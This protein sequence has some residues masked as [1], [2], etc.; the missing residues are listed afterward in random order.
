MTKK[1]FIRI[2]QFDY[3]VIE[4]EL[5]KKNISAAV[6]KPLEKM[7]HNHKLLAEIINEVMKDYNDLTLAIFKLIEEILP[8]EIISTEDIKKE[9]NEKKDSEN[10]P[11]ENPL[12]NGPVSN[13][14][15]DPNSNP[16]RKPEK[17][18]GRPRSGLN[19]L[20]LGKVTH[21][22]LTP[23]EIICP[24][25]NKNMHKQ[26]TKTRTYV[27]SIPLLST[28]THT[29]E[30]YRCLA[31]N[32]EATAQREDNLENECIGRYHFSAVAALAALRYQCGM[33]SYR[34][35]K[36]S[37]SV[38]IAVSDSTQWSLFEGA[39]SKVQ[40]FV[41]FLEKTLAN[42][43]KKHID[44]THN[45]ILSVVKEIE[46]EQ[47]KAIKNGK[48]PDDVRSG[49]HTTNVTG[50][51][52]YGEIVLYKTGLHHSGEILA[53][54]LSARTVDEQVIIMADASSSN[55][56]KLHLK[57]NEEEN[58]IK[59]ANCNSHALRKF[60]DIAKSEE[61]V[62]KKFHIKNYQ[63][64]ESVSFFL[65]R[66]GQ[67]FKNDQKTKGMTSSERLLFHKNNSFPLMEEMKKRVD[68]A[69]LN[70]E[71]EPNE[72]IGG[73]YKYF[74]NQYPR[75]C[76]FCHFENAPVCNN[77]SE[78]MLKSIIRHRKNSLF[79]KTQ[80]GA[81]VADILTT[82]FFTAK[83]N[84][85]NSVEYLRDLMLYQ[86]HWEKNP[87]EWLPWNYVATAAKL[88]NTTSPA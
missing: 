25:C 59:I 12:D 18:K 15:S 70:K 73:A 79:F 5:L 42:A 84:G 86:S 13:G 20:P 1:S 8:P 29:R 69:T 24:C 27:L 22:K 67:I 26:R 4:K 75:L 35:E 52:S 2:Q 81:T 51:F 45:I 78:R 66:Y 33:S 16:N 54:I 82:I 6:R 7:I 80:L 58:N 68:E 62:A 61:E 77:L 11:P 37:D 56:S 63:I 57:E 46:A 47:E 38:G 40:P 28:Q 76:A 72:D 3:K 43:P 17:I 9:D 44:D 87:H 34:M 39:A 85:I 36:M 65:S 71:F 64:S 55:T 31:C 21:H 14:Q 30:S 41:S 83:A 88:K 50:V 32:T 74:K 10:T 23:G 49:I 19:K 48:N 53:K 60:K